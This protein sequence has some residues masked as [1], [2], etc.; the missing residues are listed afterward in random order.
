[1]SSSARIPRIRN[2]R[3]MQRG[4]PSSPSRE[5]CNEYCCFLTRPG[6]ARFER[7]SPAIRAADAAARGPVLSS[8]GLIF[9]RKASMMRAAVVARVLIAR[10][11]QPRSCVPRRLS[12]ET[13]PSDHSSCTRL[14]LQLRSTSRHNRHVASKGFRKTEA[15]AR[16]H[17]SPGLN[18]PFGLTYMSS[19]RGHHVDQNARN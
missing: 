15:L 5:S 6:V 16:L 18:F 14:A 1:M 19:K 13:R 10:R 3:T 7:T 12:R 8:A 11:S 4:N 2:S 9:P 17:W